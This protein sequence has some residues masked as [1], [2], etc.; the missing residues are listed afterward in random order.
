MFK[1]GGAQGGGAGRQGQAQ[2]GGQGAGGP[3][4][5]GRMGEWM[6]SPISIDAQVHEMC[7]NLLNVRNGYKQIRDNISQFCN[8]PGKAKGR[9]IEIT[10]KLYG[11]LS[12]LRVGTRFNIKFYR[13]RSWSFAFIFMCQTL[14]T[15]P[16][17]NA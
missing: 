9:F 12:Q 17:H 6:M 2:G 1:R 3:G 15:S 5:P 16:I 8:P 4:G 13:H 7:L 11:Y 14:V 10:E